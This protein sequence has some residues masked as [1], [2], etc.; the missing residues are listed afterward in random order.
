[1]SDYIFG[2]KC[3]GVSIAVSQITINDDQ[4]RFD[5][6]CNVSLMNSNNGN[7]TYDVSIINKDRIQGMP[8][9][10]WRI[11]KAWINFNWG[12]SS[13]LFIMEDED[14]KETIEIVADKQK[15]SMSGFNT[16]SLTWSIFTRAQ[17]IVRDYPNALIYNAIVELNESKR[18]FNLLYLDRYRVNVLNKSDETYIEYFGS[19]LIELSKHLVVFNKVKE[20]LEE[21]DDQRSKILLKD[22]TTDCRKLLEGFKECNS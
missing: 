9:G 10:K 12:D 14:G 2:I 4:T 16:P 22:I 17:E 13:S 1:M 11:K 6:I 15:G 8:V 20:Q 18:Y 19:A 5:Y 7:G 3:N 21:L